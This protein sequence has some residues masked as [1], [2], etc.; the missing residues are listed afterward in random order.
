MSNQP[1]LG[2]GD[3]VRTSWSED[4][5]LDGGGKVYVSTAVEL[6]VRDGETAASALRRLK[7]VHTNAHKSNIE[8]ARGGK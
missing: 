5:Y 1:L 6:K 3:V 7:A 4:V 8:T 2:E